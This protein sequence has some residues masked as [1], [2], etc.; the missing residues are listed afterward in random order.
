[1]RSFFFILIALIGLNLNAQQSVKKQIQFAKGEISRDNF[2]KAISYLE[3]ITEKHPQNV[4]ALKLTGY[5][6]LNLAGQE[7]KA[8]YFLEKAAAFHPISSKKTALEIHFYR[9]KALHLNYQFEKAL[10]IF[11]QLLTLTNVKSQ[12]KNINREIGYCMNAIQLSK[13][14]RDFKI[15]SLG[16]SINSPY[17]EHSP[18]VAL[19]E[20]TIYFT[21]NRPVKGM[22]KD[23]YD[24][25]ENIYESNWRDGDWKDAQ[26]LSLPGNYFGNRATVSLSADGNTMIIYQNDGYKGSLFVSQYTYKRWA[27]P[28]FRHRRWTDPEP[29]S[30]NSVNFNE[31]HACFSP[32]GTELWFSSDRPGGYGGKD[33]YVSYLL[34]SGEWG[35][36]IN[37]GTTIN[38]EYDEDSPFIS[39]DGKTMYFASE[40]H[41]SMGGFDIFSSQKN[42]TTKEWGKV[43]NIGYP[44]NT[45]ADDIFFLPTPDGQRFYYSSRRAGGMGGSD[46]YVI[47]FPDEDIRSLAVVAGYVLQNDD[48]PVE[49]AIVKVTDFH[50]KSYGIFRANA[51]TGKFVAIIPAGYSY[52]L[53]FEA[54]GFSSNRYEITIPLRDVYGTKQHAI[55]IPN[56][57]MKKNK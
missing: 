56:I 6:Y 18:L 22:E 21:S 10:E 11:Q 3:P 55:F 24:Y 36:P 46:I 23:E 42:E 40:G 5:C 37:A 34:P 33:I 28:V 47:V 8:L 14:P 48:S 1:M 12:Q 20:P 25:Y 44:I 29:F 35:T 27:E 31:T 51:L 49:N 19:D 52:T 13:N 17:D 54:D 4:E 50:D 43:E 30:I 32:D 16:E 9:A 15:F 53:E 2:R 39:P 38:T 45:P 26:L 7:E 57:V 41:N